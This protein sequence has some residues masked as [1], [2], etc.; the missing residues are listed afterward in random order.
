MLDAA[1]DHDRG[2][3][4]IDLSCY[5]RHSDTFGTEAMPRATRSRAPLASLEANVS[6]GSRFLKDVED[7]LQDLEAEVESRCATLRAMADDAA[8]ALRQELKLQLLKLPK[9]VRSMPLQ[10]FKEKFSEDI[11]AV[12]LQNI[13]SKLG[14]TVVASAASPKQA[15]PRTVSR[16]RKRKVDEDAPK[17]PGTALRRSKRSTIGEPKT[18]GRSLSS[19]TPGPG[20]PKTPGRVIMP[21][22]AKRAPR[23]HEVFFSENGSPLGMYLEDE[24]E[25]LDVEK[26]LKLKA[27]DG[28]EI[29]L[30]Q[31]TDLP[32]SLRKAALAKLMGLQDQV[33][34]IMA[35][36]DS[37]Q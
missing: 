36:F 27:D 28:T 23:P 11:N 7:A 12:L 3:R 18:P 2:V 9:K 21:A 35:Q 4:L 14:D 24:G 32:A 13:N 5:E 26:S 17:A 6:H 31:V 30:A 20:V 1:E 10:E 16:S 15:V 34:S 33:R 22:T 25:T 37:V 8:T 29:D 19:T